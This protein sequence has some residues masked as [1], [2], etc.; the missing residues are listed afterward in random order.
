[1][2]LHE[3]P[4]KRPHIAAMNVVNMETTML[5]KVRNITPKKK[6]RSNG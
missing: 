1:M 6:G 3:P 2:N 5:L 4:P